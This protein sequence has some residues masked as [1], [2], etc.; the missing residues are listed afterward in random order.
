MPRLAFCVFAKHLHV[1]WDSGDIVL[2]LENN[3]VETVLFDMLSTLK[4][5]NIS[6]IIIP[7]G[8]APF[9]Q[10]RILRATQLGL[11][12]GL[13][14]TALMVNMFDVLFTATDLQTGS[15]FLET[16]RGDYF[17]QTRK[18]GKIVDEGISTD[19]ILGKVRQH[20]DR[21]PIS[22]PVTGSSS[23]NP[24]DHNLNIINGSSIAVL[25][26]LA[27]DDRSSYSTIISDNPSLA[28]I[29]ITKNLA[30][31]MLENNFTLCL[32]LI[33]GITLPYSTNGII[34]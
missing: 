24:E 2:P 27:E 30:K 17:F 28:T 22:Y 6:G 11:A 7:A 5:N 21:G 8:P 34:M 29:Q 23:S 33:Y 10:L 31:T 14:C 13:K 9:T 1:A 15:C 32:D 26:H 3:R 18:D 20:R 12:T 4:I 19:V 25:T 16:R